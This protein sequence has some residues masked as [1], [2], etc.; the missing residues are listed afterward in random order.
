[1]QIINNCITQRLNTFFF[2]FIKNKKKKK[3]EKSLLIFKHVKNGR[4]NQGKITIRHRGGGHKKLYRK[5]DL[6]RNLTLK[7]YVK[8]IHYDPNR[9]AKLALIIYSN[10]CKRYILW[11]QNLSFGNFIL[12]NKIKILNIGNNLFLKDIPVG[13]HIHNIEIKKN[14]GGQLVRAAGTSAKI[15]TKQENYVIIRLP[16]KEI[17][18]INKNCKATIGV[19]GIT[20]NTN[21][22]KAGKKRWL[23]IR[24]TVR[25]VAMNACDHPHGGGEGKSPIGRKTPLTPWGKITL[26]KKTRKTKNSFI[27]KRRN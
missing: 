15:L 14:G 2:N 16:S 25:G 5:I 9:S 23:G 4:N 7:G 17:R 13:F 26:G 20:T 12:T 21:Y 27:I 11:P 8:A 3:N 19:V 22:F 18:L 24:P 6:K 10:G 1:M